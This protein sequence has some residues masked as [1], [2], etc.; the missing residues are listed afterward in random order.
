MTTFL[1]IRHGET[2]YV[3]RSL[4]GRIPGIH[5]NPR[6][7]DQA[8][9]LAE[10]LSSL[11][12][13]AV[14][15]S[16]LERTLETASPLARRLGLEVQVREGVTELDFGDWTGQRFDALQTVPAWHWYNTFRSGTRIP[17]GERAIE[18]QARAVA[19]LERLGLEHPQGMVALVSHADVIRAVLCYFAAIP[20]DLLLRVV[21]DP[22][23]VSVLAIDPW[24]PRILR[25]NDTGDL[26]GIDPR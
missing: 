8:E 6:G 5:L 1:L 3:G 21:I 26:A 19:E 10:R 17:G 4:A 24:G 2:D 25:V 20:I 13:R 7:I 9:R 16:P 15:S 18:V 23:S 11:P 12:I 14:V 22:A